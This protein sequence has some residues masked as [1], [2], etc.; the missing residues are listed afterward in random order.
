VSAYLEAVAERY[1]RERDDWRALADDLAAVLVELMND[2]AIAPGP[3]TEQLLA[4]YR[5]ARQR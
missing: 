4:R 3:V 1:R 2:F 5:E